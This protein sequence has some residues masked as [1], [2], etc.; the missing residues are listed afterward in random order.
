MPKSERVGL[1]VWANTYTTAVLNLN[2]ERLWY[3]ITLI[4]IY[5]FI[6]IKVLF[7][8]LAKLL[9]FAF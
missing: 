3:L 7:Y 4:Q 8:H 2:T 6:F 9:S 5:A 1:G